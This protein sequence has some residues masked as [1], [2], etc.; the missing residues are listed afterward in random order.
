MRGRLAAGWVVGVGPSRPPPAQ[1]DAYAEPGPAGK[2]RRRRP[3]LR[4]LALPAGPEPASTE[5][6]STADGM[7]GLSLGVLVAAGL[8]LEGD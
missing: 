8:V 7:A 2:A 1:A 6:G 3:R 4:G 5:C